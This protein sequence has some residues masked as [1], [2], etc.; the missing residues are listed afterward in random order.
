MGKVFGRGERL[1]PIRRLNKPI[2]VILICPNIHNN[3]ALDF[4][5]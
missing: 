1:G 4:A 2:S 5:K 3:K